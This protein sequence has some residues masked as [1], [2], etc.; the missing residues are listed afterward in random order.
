MTIREQICQATDTLDTLRR[1]YFQQRAT[2]EQVA[3]AATTL[4]ELRRE[5]ELR[6]KKRSSIQ[7]NAVSIARLIRSSV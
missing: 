5:A 1:E 2:Y 3:E 6:F 7:I 4:L